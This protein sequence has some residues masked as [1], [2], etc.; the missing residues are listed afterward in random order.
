[1][2][3]IIESKQPQTKVF[4]VRR[5]MKKTSNIDFPL[6]DSGG[7]FQV[8]RSGVDKVIGEHFK[9]VF[10]QNEVPDDPLWKEYWKLPDDIFDLIDV[11]TANMYCV[12]DEPTFTEI[13]TIIREMSAS[14]SSFGS[15]SIDLA[16]L[17]GEKLSRFIYRCI[18][19]CFQQNALPE[20]K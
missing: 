4:S 17:G 12:E 6:K 2:Q 15:L 14:K 8:S 10:T 9:K 1:M 16:K 19:V 11:I 18:L 5:N 20:V 13:D 7:V 3:T